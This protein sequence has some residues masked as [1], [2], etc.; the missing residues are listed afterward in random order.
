MNRTMQTATCTTLR[1]LESTLSTWER[2]IERAEDQGDDY[3][4]AVALRESMRAELELAAFRAR[5]GEDSFPTAQ[6]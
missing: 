3:A 2:R 5:M 6:Y 4:F 1:S